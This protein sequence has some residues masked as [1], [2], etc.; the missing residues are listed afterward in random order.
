METHLQ[1]RVKHFETQ[2]Q[3]LMTLILLSDNQ[4]NYWTNRITQYRALQMDE[5]IVCSDKSNDKIDMIE[6]YIINYRLILQDMTEKIIFARK[7]LFSQQRG[8]TV[9]SC[10]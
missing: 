4:L 9:S 1:E 5:T 8:L 2:L 3:H 7:I 10:P 6:D